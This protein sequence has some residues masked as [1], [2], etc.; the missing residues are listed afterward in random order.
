[1]KLTVYTDGASRGNPGPAAVG[2]VVFD[3]SGSPVLTGKRTLG[4][5]T[6]NMAEYMAVKLSLE[7]IL[8]RYLSQTPLSVDYIGDSQLIICQL[9]GK[10]KVKNEGL[11][12]LYEGI[13]DLERK[14]G[15]VSYTY[16]PRVNNST[17]D[18]LANEALDES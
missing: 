1:M 16:T 5:A 11:K 9:S 3:E 7:K 18:R 17:A 12:V 4:V 14:I 15:R 6:N 10:F 2:F 13:K 8:D